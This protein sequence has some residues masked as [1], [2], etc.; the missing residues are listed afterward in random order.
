MNVVMFCPF[1]HHTGNICRNSDWTGSVK[2]LRVEAEEAMLQTRV[3]FVMSR[4]PFCWYPE[5]CFAHVTNLKLVVCNDVTKLKFFS[6][7]LLQSPRC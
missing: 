7:S 5:K 2:L 1:S 4:Q 3:K 6:F